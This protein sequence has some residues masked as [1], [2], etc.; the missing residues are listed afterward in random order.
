PRPPL[1]PWPGPSSTPHTRGAWGSQTTSPSGSL[2]PS[3]PPRRAGWLPGE[4]ACPAPSLQ[5]HY[6]TF[7]ATTSRSAP[8]PRGTL[9]QTVSAAQGPP[10]RG[11]RATSAHPDLAD[12]IE[13]Q[14]LLFHASAHDELTPP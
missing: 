14:V 3:A 9:P 13:T 11:Q 10:S 7:D 2:G 4:L 5:P 12:G 1:H 8:A 6:R